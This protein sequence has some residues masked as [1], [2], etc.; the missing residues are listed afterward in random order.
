MRKNTVPPIGWGNP[1]KHMSETS[2][3]FTR[4]GLKPA[5]DT[6]LLLTTEPPLGKKTPPAA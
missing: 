2:I 6:L 1:G 3:G 4:L 5:G